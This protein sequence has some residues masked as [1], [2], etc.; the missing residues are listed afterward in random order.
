MKRNVLCVVELDNY[1][2]DVVARAAWLAKL[3]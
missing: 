3:L 1:P 2:E